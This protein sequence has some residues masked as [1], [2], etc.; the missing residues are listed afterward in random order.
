MVDTILRVSAWFMLGLAFVF[1]F[2]YPFLIG[3]KIRTVFT[4]KEYAF[5]AVQGVLMAFI[6]GRILGWW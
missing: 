1:I 4:L 3:K 6:A 5:K 2:V